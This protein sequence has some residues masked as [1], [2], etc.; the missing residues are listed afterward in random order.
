[1]AELPRAYITGGTVSIGNGDSSFTGTGTG[2]GINDLEGAELWI[3]PA[4]AAS[5]MVGVVAAIDPRYPAGQYENL[6]PIPLVLS[7]E[8]AAI[9]DESRYVLK[10]S[11]AIVSSATVAAILARLVA[12]IE[13]KAGLVYNSAD[14]PNYTDG[15]VENNSLI[16]NTVTRQI[17]QWRS[18]VLDTVFAVGLSDNPS[19]PWIGSPIAKTALAISSGDVD[20]DFD[21]GVLD[22]AGVSHFA[23][24]VDGAAEL[25]LPTNVEIGS[26]FDVLFTIDTGPHAIT[27]AAGYAAGIAD[28]IQS[29]D[30]ART[31]IRF[32]VTDVSGST[33]TAVSAAAVTFA[34]NDLVEDQGALFVSNADSNSAEPQFSGGNPAS[35]E[36]W[37]WKPGPT[38]T[39]VL[40]A[41]GLNSLTVSESAASGD[42]GAGTHLWLQV[43]SS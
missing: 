22:S 18:G 35:D 6:G 33:A 25:Q 43:P 28:L 3:C 40:D 10:L 38:V 4:D 12:H 9:V 24:T 42:P 39:S 20:I 36:N 17:Q 15:L 11:V 27:F 37:T 31:R 41:L 30:D 2:F 23:L 5:F 26:A 34:K 21:A 14:E 32:T 8:G 7:Y 1:M 16:I 29:A 13:Q 19:G